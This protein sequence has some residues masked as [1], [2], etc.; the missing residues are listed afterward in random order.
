MSN[1]RIV[2]YKALNSNGTLKAFL[3]VEIVK[4]ALQING[5]MFHK[6]D[7]SQWI[8][9]PMKEYVSGK[10]KKFAPMI[11]FRDEAVFGRFQSAV[12]KAVS[13]YKPSESF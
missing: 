12:L 4:W 2:S 7:K 6:T 1:I 5:I 10:D 11:E 3:K 9:L 13:E 8:Q